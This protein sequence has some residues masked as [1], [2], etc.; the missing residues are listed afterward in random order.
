M[1]SPCD[2][3]AVRAECQPY[4]N[5]YTAADGVFIKEMCIPKAGTLVPQHSHEYDHTSFVAKG[6][7]ICEGITYRA[8]YP[9]Y[10]RAGV[11]HMFESLEDDTMVLCIHNVSRTGSVEVREEHQIVR[12]A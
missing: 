11:K 8:P 4:G 1:N 9:I 7:V 10:I 3:C 12:A 5:E 2:T 6:A